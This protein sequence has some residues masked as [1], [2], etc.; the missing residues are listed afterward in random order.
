MPRYWFCR[1]YNA[2]GELSS[3]TV[4]ILGAFAVSSG[5]GG[6]S[7]FTFN[8]FASSGS[9]GWCFVVV[10][11]VLAE[12]ALYCGALFLVCGIVA[13]L[14]VRCSLQHPSPFCMFVD[15]ILQE[16]RQPSLPC[17]HCCGASV[18]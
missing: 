17:L 8:G 14:E 2:S 4:S 18:R 7:I 10:C 1:R 3:S 5:G 12:C 13:S 11:V 15:T 6:V 16:I 9:I